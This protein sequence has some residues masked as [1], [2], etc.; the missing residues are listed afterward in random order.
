MR[1]DHFIIAAPIFNN[2]NTT[3]IVLCVYAFWLTLTLS[4]GLY[5][6]RWEI[7][8]AFL[9]QVLTEVPSLKARELSLVINPKTPLLKRRL[10]LAPALIVG[11]MFVTTLF[12][13]AAAQRFCIGRFNCCIRRLLVISARYIP[14]DGTL[15]PQPSLRSFR[16]IAGQ[17]RIWTSS[18]RIK[19][20]INQI[21]FLL[22]C[23]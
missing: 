3:C 20:G 19:H 14:F 16:P 8:W 2:F 23:L 9:I 11:Y 22:R 10:R 6:L 21:L 13:Q 15:L 12:R 7:H 17:K 4:W 18:R 1:K 5:S